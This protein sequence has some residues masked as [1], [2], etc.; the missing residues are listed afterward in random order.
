MIKINSVLGSIFESTNFDRTNFEKLVISR[1]D[2]EKRILRKKTD[3]GTDIGIN[4]DSGIKLQHGDIIGNNETK[5]VVEQIPEKV[6]SVKLK[7]NNQNIAILLG[8]IIG[9]R[10]RPIAIKD[11][12]ILFPIQENSELEIFQRLFIEIIDHI[13]LKI[14]EQIFLP[15]T[16]ADVHEH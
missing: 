16:S 3:L 12:M 9:N 4:L 5:I 13:E 11:K 14:E 10:H 2:L 6:I 8:H 7:E 1:I 15:H